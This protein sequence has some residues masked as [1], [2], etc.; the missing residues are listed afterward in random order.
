ML[1]FALCFFHTDIG[2]ELDINGGELGGG[3]IV[4]PISEV[5]ICFCIFLCFSWCSA[6][7]LTAVC[8]M[9]C[10]LAWMDEMICCILRL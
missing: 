9:T 10:T 3:L 5:M 2:D 8:L 4:R 7:L 6:A 1:W